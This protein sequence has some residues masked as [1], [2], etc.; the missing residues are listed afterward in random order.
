MANDRIERVKALLESLPG[1]RMAW[2]QPD[3]PP[4]R[5]R[6]GMAITDPRTLSRVVHLACAHN[7]TLAVEVDWNCG[8]I[9]LHDDP[10]CIRY[11]LR[12]GTAVRGDEPSELEDLEGALPRERDVLRRTS[13][14]EKSR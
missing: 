9:H 7:L 12:V 8:P 2:C 1:V 4:G 13:D 3:M 6:F 5:V 10:A 14:N 11:D